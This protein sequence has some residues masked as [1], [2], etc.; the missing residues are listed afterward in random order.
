MVDSPIT[1][2]QRSVQEILGGAIQPCDADS[3]FI[4]SDNYYQWYD[5]IGFS[6]KPDD[7]IEIGVRFGYSAIAMLRGARAAG[8]DPDYC[9]FDNEYDMKGSN[10]IAEFL[11]RRYGN[12]GANISVTNP[13]EDP[14]FESRY[15]GLADL[16]HVDGDHSEDGIRRELSWAH[17]WAAPGG[18]ILVDDAEVRHIHKAAMEFA[19]ERR[20]FSQFLPT[21]RGMLVL[22]RQRDVHDVVNVR[23]AVNIL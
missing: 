6:K 14:D 12:P 3:D 16:V 18:W 4:L 2:S 7:I 23:Q 20:Y 17:R 19:V 1:K 9:G 22:R 21:L 15:R 5:A 13:Y 11:I 10:A 8:A